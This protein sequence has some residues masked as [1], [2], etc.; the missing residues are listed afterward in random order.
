VKK[1]WE[2][3][4]SFLFNLEMLIVEDQP[5]KALSLNQCIFNGRLPNN[6]RKFSLGG[7][8]CVA[9]LCGLFGSSKMIQSSTRLS[10]KML[11]LKE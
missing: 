5:R 10:G 7:L 9:L 3:A 4:F 1:A 11:N 2:L 8:C 6:L